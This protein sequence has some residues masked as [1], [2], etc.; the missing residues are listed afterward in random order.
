FPAPWLLPPLAPSSWLGSGA[1]SISSC[2][3][4]LPD[5][6]LR[7]HLPGSFLH[8]LHPGSS[9]RLLLPGCLLHMR[10]LGCCLLSSSHHPHAKPPPAALHRECHPVSVLSSSLCHLIFLS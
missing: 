10:L 5:S 4:L 8:H 1:S 9:L 6:S 7:L 2:S 3:G